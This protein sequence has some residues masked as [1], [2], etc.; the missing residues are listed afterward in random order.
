MMSSQEDSRRGAS[1]CGSI[2]SLLV[3]TCTY[4]VDKIHP[5]P[6]RLGRARPNEY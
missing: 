2:A 5:W 4:A 1:D 6:A 3:D